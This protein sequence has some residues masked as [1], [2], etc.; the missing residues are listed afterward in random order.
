[1]GYP[2]EMG[3]LV[4][5][6]LVVGEK[7]N[8]YGNLSAPIGS[9]SWCVGIRAQAWSKKHDEKSAVEHLQAWLRMLFADNHFQALED[10]DGNPFVLWEDFV[11]YREPFGLEMRVSFAKA[12]MAETDPT[13]AVEI[14]A[15]DVRTAEADQARVDA[16]R[17][18]R[19]GDRKSEA[20]LAGAAAEAEATRG[21]EIKHTNGMLDP[22]Q[23]GNLDYLRR[24]MARH[25][26]EALS[27]WERGEYPSVRAAALAAGIIKEKTLVE[28][29]IALWKRAT[30][31]ERD[32]IRSLI[33]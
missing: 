5:P 2:D 17:I 14:I 16:E 30:P 32:E 24:R 9:R 19:G 4:R 1:M 26:P 15:R 22:R 8:D 3:A 31:D 33:N 7:F 18:K 20:A 12:V 6:H 27:A 29:V 13:K 10:A 28:R 25:A 21:S 11:Q 23:G